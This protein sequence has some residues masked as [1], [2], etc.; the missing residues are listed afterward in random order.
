MMEFYLKRNTTS[1][2][3]GIV[4]VFLSAL[5]LDLQV[6]SIFHCETK[7]TESVLTYH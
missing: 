3:K 6:N 2:D 1:K 7:T 5:V 4:Y